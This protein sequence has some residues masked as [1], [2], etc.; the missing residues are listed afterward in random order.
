METVACWFEPTWQRMG[1]RKRGRETEMA[2]KTVI[3]YDNSNWK[4]EEPPLNVNAL[5]E[6]LKLKLANVPE[7]YRDTCVIEYSATT[8]WDSPVLEIEMKY[9][10][11]ETAEEEQA[12]ITEIAIRREAQMN[13]ERAVYEQL[14]AKFGNGAEAQ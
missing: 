1:R 8:E 12:R 14:K 3:I 9:V 6:W 10:R 2:D 4:A 7:E 13:H 5:I 11:P